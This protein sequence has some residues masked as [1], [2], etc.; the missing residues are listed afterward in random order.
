VQQRREQ[1]LREGKLS[2]GHQDNADAHGADD[3]EL[4]KSEITYQVL[5]E[6]LQAQTRIDEPNAARRKQY[7]LRNLKGRAAPPT[8]E[9]LRRYRFQ[10]MS[11]LSSFSGA[12]PRLSLGG[13]NRYNP[14]PTF[15]TGHGQDVA[16]RTKA[17]LKPLKPLPPEVA[18]AAKRTFL[19][20]LRALTY[21]SLLGFG[22]LAF[23]TTFLIQTSGSE[24]FQSNVR[25]SVR[26]AVQPLGQ[27]IRRTLQPWRIWAQE[28]LGVAK[29]PDHGS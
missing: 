27:N 22:L 1:M 8:E 12:I 4:H 20:G 26:S 28:K 15:E 9:E 19:V 18:E 17:A 14:L 5:P 13:R 16:E 23:G 24:R 3:N 21:G 29:R 11:A 10:H 7:E 2:P 25:E 6:V